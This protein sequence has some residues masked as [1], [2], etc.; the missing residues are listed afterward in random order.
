MEVMR[1][2]WALWKWWWLIALAVILAAAASYWSNA[3]RPPVY[4]TTTTLRVGRSLESADPLL[5]DINT[6]Q[7]LAQLYAG[8]VKRRALLQVTADALQLDTDWESLAMQ[9]EAY[10]PAG[11]QLIQIGVWDT[12]PERAKAIA[13]ELAHQLILHSPTAQQEKAREE[14]QQFID[15]QLSALRAR[16]EEADKQIEE[17]DHQVLQE[18][19]A[20]RI[21]AIQDRS[22]ALQQKI[23]GWQTTYADLLTSYGGSPTNYLTIIDPA[24]VPTTPTGPRTMSTILM[25]SIVGLLLAVGGALAMEYLDDTLRAEADVKQVLALETLGSVS[26]LGK[27]STPP[28]ALVTIREPGSP[29]SGMYDLLCT[30]IQFECIDDPSLAFLVTSASP[31]EGKSITAANL[32]VSFAKAGKRTVLV[33]A[34]LRHPS[35]HQLFGVANDAG[36]SSIFLSEPA[37]LGDH[38]HEREARDDL[39]QRVSDRVIQTKVPDLRVLPSGP[40]PSNPPRVLRSQRMSQ[41]LE[42]LQAMADVVILDCPPALPM[43]DAVVLA[44][45]VKGVVLVAEVGRT[46]CQAA[47][48]TKQALLRAHARIIGVVLNK[49]PRRDVSYYGYGYGY[50]SQKPE[51]AKL[52][53]NVSFSIPRFR[54]PSPL[55]QVSEGDFSQ[56]SGTEF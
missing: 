21:Q 23:A 51:R 40:L 22:A 49:A 48:L 34:D 5:S 47:R 39:P 11:T 19:S 32:A 18:T 55:P 43:P 38:S 2:V 24:P 3:S 6:S 27:L 37:R 10:A 9:V 13:D 29:G 25:A 1:Y 26:D 14:Q 8:T 50:Y 7:Q 56:P 31:K 4:Q 53:P 46:R 20:I 12:N 17:L 54:R 28:E 36:L 16:I 30:N 15:R 44:A 33:D 45:R 42:A 35:V 41:V 52:S